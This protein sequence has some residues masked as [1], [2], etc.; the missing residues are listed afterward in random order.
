MQNLDSPMEK[1]LTFAGSQKNV[2]AVAKWLGG[3]VAIG[4]VVIAIAVAI[5]GHVFIR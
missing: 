1:L 3:S 4:T 2:D 5:V